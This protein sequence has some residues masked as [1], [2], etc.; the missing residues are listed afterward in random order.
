MASNKNKGYNMRKKL[1]FYEA[2]RCN[3]AWRES[4]YITNNTF[5]FDESLLYRCKH[6]QC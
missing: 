5:A 1:M 6:R 2:S 4:F 3:T